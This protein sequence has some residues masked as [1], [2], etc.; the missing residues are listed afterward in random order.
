MSSSEKSS[1]IIRPSPYASELVDT[2]KPHAEIKTILPRRRLHFAVGGTTY[3]YLILEGNVAI[4]RHS[5]DRLLVSVS[6]PAVY[7]IARQVIKN[8]DIYLTT[9]TPTVIGKIPVEQAEK[10]I[11]DKGLWETLSRHLMVSIEKLYVYNAQISAPTAFDVVCGQLQELMSEESTLRMNL[12]AERYIRNKTSLS[13]SRVMQVLS[14][15]KKGGYIEL[16]RGILLGI[17]H[18]PDKY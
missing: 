11:T 13:R 14:D 15:L 9:V 4:H 12:T 1:L 8:M 3:C 18:L 6:S 5:D 16:E 10:I 7:G 17:N 2:L